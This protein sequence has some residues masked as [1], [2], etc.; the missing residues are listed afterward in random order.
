M[1]WVFS[2]ACCHED[3]SYKQVRAG[4]RDK[5]QWTQRLREVLRMRLRSWQQ[6]MP[7]HHTASCS[8]DTIALS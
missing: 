5:E 4:P 8:Y 6:H 2:S 1:S 3:A 7:C